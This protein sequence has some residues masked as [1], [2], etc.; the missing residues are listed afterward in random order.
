[1]KKRT[2]IFGSLFI[3]V[4]VALGGMMFFS[5]DEG[6]QYDTVIAQRAALVQEVDITGRVEA[7]DAVDLAF[8]RSGRVAIIHK[9]VNEQVQAGETL[10]ALDTAN[11]RAKVAQAQAGLATAQARLLQEEAA[12]R[13]QQITLEE[14][15]R[16]TRIEE[17]RIAE[18]TVENAEK[19]LADAQASLLSTQAKADVDLA[20]VYDDVS[21]TLNDAFNKADDAL[22]KQTDELFTNATKP[23]FAFTSL[24]AQAVADAENLRLSA[25]AEVDT[26]KIMID[27]LPVGQYDALDTAMKDAE[28][29]LIVVRNYLARTLDAVDRIANLS[30]TTIATYEGNIDTARSNMNTALTN[31]NTVEQAVAAQKALNTSNNTTADGVVNDA[32]SAL[33]AAERN[34]EL[35]RAG[36][37]QEQ[38]QAQETKVE[39]AEANVA[40]QKAQVSREHANVAGALADLATAEIQAPFDATVTDVTISVGEIVSANTT[41]ISL[42]AE[43]ELEIEALIPEADITKVQVSN[44][45]KLTLDAYGD[46]VLFDAIV[47]DI[48]PAAAL[49]DGVATYKTT[50]VLQD[51]SVVVKAGM[52]ADIDIITAQRGNAIAV[53]QRAVIF[54]DGRRIVRILNNTGTVEEREVETG[55]IGNRGLI[56]IVSGLQ[57]GERVVTS[58]RNDS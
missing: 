25:E 22:Y 20:N 53:P 1:M 51:P 45:A 39:Q 36:T 5:G 41:V 6:P 47:T 12:L 18:T 28:N 8:E 26:L 7:V 3:V 46:D 58:V 34:L 11:L 54:T 55:I 57:E 2:K 24:D 52:T 4:I 23:R 21:D 30:D 9:D 43:E 15:Q 37:T 29:S 19:D 10:V 14:L 38:I 27:T 35:K 50:L 32:Q 33:R 17:I 56:E 16:G 44:K 42:I 13:Q 49:T 40:A 31:I 48:H